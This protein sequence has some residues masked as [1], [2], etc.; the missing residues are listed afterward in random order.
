MLGM[1]LLGAH[2]SVSGGAEKAVAR[3]TELGCDA[4]QIFVKSPNRWTNAPRPS[5][6]SDRFREERERSGMPV[7]AH[8]GYLVNL[9]SSTAEVAEKSRRSLVD[10]LRRC[11]ALGVPGLV[12]HPGAPQDAGR[13][14]GIDRVAA[15]LDAVLAE[16]A[17]APVRI[18]LENTAGQGSTLGL[19]PSELQAIRARV[20]EPTRVGICLDTCHAFAA[21][22]DLRSEDGYQRLVGEVA[23]T[24][25]LETVF[26]WHLNDS[27]FPL[28]KNRDR[29]A[30]IGEGEI[31]REAFARLLADVRFAELPMIL[32]TPLGDDEG[33]HAR[34]LATLRTLAGGG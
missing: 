5:S 6:E 29:H 3:A 4:F 7:V 10:E 32:E 14:V 15:G 2:V 28:G 34:D 9:A 30:N 27:K 18:L 20:S 16:V 26:A 22:Y 24:V 33:G 17:D 25:G 8:A 1:G 13:D 12:L 19:S 23:D 21:G 31:G 11:A